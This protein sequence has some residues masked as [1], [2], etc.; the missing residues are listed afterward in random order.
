M[1]T[2]KQLTEKDRIEVYAMKQAGKKQ[3]LI[4]SKSL[5]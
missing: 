2:Y 3:N 5:S 1:R 4:V